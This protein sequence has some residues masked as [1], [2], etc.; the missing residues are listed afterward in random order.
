MTGACPVRDR[1]DLLRRIDALARNTDTM[2]HPLWHADC[3]PERTAAAVLVP[4]IDDATGLTVLLTRR[5]ARLDHHPGQI[6]FPGGR[7][8]ADDASPVA[9]A[10]R[11]TREE[12]GLE[13]ENIRVLGGMDRIHSN[14]GFCII[15]VIALVRSGCRLKL[16]R[17][18]VD[19]VFTAPLGFFLQEANYKRGS[20]TYNGERHVFHELHYQGRRIW[21]ITAGILANFRGMLFDGIKIRF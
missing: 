20:I 18:E 17:L 16:D 8:E 9:T 14:S 3:E 2:A 10:L 21:G 6:S 1:E 15:P 11:E 19:E 5:S 7:R 13:A 12:I 4:I